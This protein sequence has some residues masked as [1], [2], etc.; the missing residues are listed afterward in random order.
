VDLRPGTI[1]RINE[2]RFAGETCV[3]VKKL[4]IDKKVYVIEHNG[5]RYNYDLESI[6]KYTDPY[7][8]PYKTDPNLAFS[9]RSDK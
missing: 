3:I 8:G 4:L 5:K 1:R 6:L 9:R 2:G 7:T